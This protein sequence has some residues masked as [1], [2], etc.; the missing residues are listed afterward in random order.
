MEKLK[1]INFDKT[2]ILAQIKELDTDK[3][4]KLKLSLNSK[5]KF[6]QNPK[7]PIK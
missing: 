4:Q 5:P 2:Q 6:W 7:N 3:T 1:N